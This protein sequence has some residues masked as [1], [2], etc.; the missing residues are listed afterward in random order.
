MSSK[1]LIFVYPL[2]ETMTKLK[3]S[4]E[5]IAEDEQIEVYEVDQ[6]AEIAQLVPTIG[7]SLTIYGNPKKCAM[8][9]KQLR[10]INS[11]LNSKILL[12]NQKRI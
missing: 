7:Q 2:S 11:K 12:L 5:A 6:I 9:L 10:K 8:A 3:E 4:I 1:P